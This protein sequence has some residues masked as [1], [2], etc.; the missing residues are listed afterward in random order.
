M[1]SSQAVRRSVLATAIVLVAAHGATPAL[2]KPPDAA[3]LCA[4]AV[5]T[6][7]R[8][9]QI[10][11]KLLQAIS[12]AESGHWDPS[13]RENSAWPWTVMAEGQ[14]RY[15][16][17]KETAIRA[18]RALQWKG[19]RNIDV[20]CLQVNLHYHPEA[21]GSLE[22]A[23]DPMTNAGYAAEFLVRLRRDQRSWVRAVKHYHSATP[24]LHGPYREK[25]YRIWRDERRNAQQEQYAERQRRREA[26]ETVGG[27]IL[28]MADRVLND[29][30]L[31]A[32]ARLWLED[33]AAAMI[34]NSAR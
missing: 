20:G 11:S 32:R 29:D 33:V 18:V 13:R 14:G 16:P 1:V 10:P 3:G 2:A 9:H 24:E 6:Q 7:E 8:A 4:R 28:K 26:G 15:Y 21:F 30:R 17:T 31:D 22:D 34:R 25:V 19:I 27:R 12:I 23:F 5:A